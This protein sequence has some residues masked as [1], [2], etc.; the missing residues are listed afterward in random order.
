MS[1]TEQL[2][3]LWDLQML[4]A[5]ILKRRK[6]LKEIEA[7]PPCAAEARRLLERR[8]AAERALEEARSELTALE[9]ELAHTEERRKQTHKRL[10]GGTVTA[11]RELNALEHELAALKERQNE[12]DGQVLQAMDRVTALEAEANQAVSA[13][14]ELLEQYRTEKASLGAEKQRIEA[15]LV[16]LSSRRDRAAQRVDARQLSRYETL[17]QRGGGYGMSPVEEDHCKLCRTA[18]SVTVMKRLQG[19]AIVQ[20]ENCSRILYPAKS[21]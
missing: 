8:Q 21:A 1:D 3:L 6:R 14:T 10:Y 12:L 7:G 11:T 17:R 15:E 20:C 13:S 5:K 16:D 19:G 9:T 18:I 2:E 4:D